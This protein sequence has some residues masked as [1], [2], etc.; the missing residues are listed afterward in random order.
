MLTVEIEFLFAVVRDVQRNGRLSLGVLSRTCFYSLSCE[1]YSGTVQLPHV[2]LSTEV[3]IRCRARRTAELTSLTFQTASQRFYSLSCETYSGTL[4]GTWTVVSPGV[5]IRCRAR[6][7]AERPVISGSEPLS[8]G[9]LFA[10]VRDVQRNRDHRSP[11][12]AH[13]V[14]IR[15]RARRTAEHG[16]VPDDTPKYME[17]LFAV[18]RDVQRNVADVLPIGV[19]I[20]F[21]FA[22]VRDVQRNYIAKNRV[23]TEE[24]RWFLFAVVR[25]VQR[26]RVSRSRPRPHHRFYSLSCETYSGTCIYVGWECAG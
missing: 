8:R 21:L 12:T 4:P 14:S 17:F 19:P 6:R 5:S 2:L 25:D 3:S 16:M 20:R 22:V 26:N 15:C 13:H 7:T 10:V 23:S 11:T 9:F 1:T 24:T 18:V